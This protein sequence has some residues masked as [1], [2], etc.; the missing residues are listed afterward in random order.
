MLAKKAMN[1]LL[2]L[3]LS[4]LFLAAA[5][6]GGNDTTM[7][8]REQQ[9]ASMPDDTAKVALLLELGKHYCSRENDRALL[10]F[11]QASA[12]STELGFRRGAGRSYLWQGRT[13]YYKDEYA[14]A[15]AY[16][17]RARE[18]L[19]KEGDASD[20][21]LWHFAMA[22]LKDVNGDFNLAVKEYQE[23]IRLAGM[24]GDEKLKA[25]SLV[26]LGSIINRMN[27]PDHALE[28]FREALAIQQRVGEEP[29]A[30]S[31]FTNMGSAFEA[32]GLFDSA[33]HFY[34]KGY[35]IRLLFR[36][37]RPIANSE[38]SLGSLFI[39]MNRYPEAITLFEAARERYLVL[40]EKVGICMVELQL[41]VALD[42]SGKR[43]RAWETAQHALALAQETGNLAMTGQCYETLASLAASGRQYEEAY[44]FTL[45]ARKISDTLAEQKKERVIKEMEGRFR[46]REANDKLEQLLLRDRVQRKNILLLSLSIAALMVALFLTI[47]LSRQKIMAHRRQKRLFEQD[48]IIREQQEA[49]AQKERQ[50]LQE[51]VE[52]RERELAAKALEMLRIN[53]TLGGLI[54]RLQHLSQAHPDCAELEEKIGSMV[55]EIEHYTQQNA[56]REFDTIFRNIHREFYDRL[57]E[58]CPDLTAAEIKIAALLKL[59]LS[60]KEIAAITMKS[61]EGIK[62]TR[63]RLRKKLHFTSDE[64]LIPFLLQL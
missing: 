11:Q 2:V 61:E 59:N 40:D 5:A 45:L 51:T 3:L 25:A 54:T 4:G 50:L 10:F 39:R 14:L 47:L 27:E 41:A 43:V 35:N 57:L 28:Y 37:P 48:I 23:A 52:T 20:L 34:R 1:R 44:R 15:D 53:E 9:L 29:G 46:L 26:S 63:Y 32:K 19:E 8:R 56:W 62:S 6:T 24:A 36:E 58:K 18:V 12:L 55:R 49:L 64:H 16:L 17:A 13:Y 31:T 21:A 38:Y 7:Q 42:R 60:T 30:A 22:T 33:L